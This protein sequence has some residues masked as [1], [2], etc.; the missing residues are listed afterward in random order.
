MNKRNKIYFSL[1]ALIALFGLLFG[2]NSCSKD[3]GKPKPPYTLP[4]T[5]FFSKHI[6]PLFNT[7]CNV[8]GCHSGSFPSGKLDL[9][10]GTAYN[11]LFKKDE[12]DTLNPE[13]S[14]LY[15]QMNQNGSPMPPDG[16]LD[17]YYIALVLK[18]IQHKAKNN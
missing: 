6:Q 3:I 11:D 18:W 17:D 12:V 16:K 1:F 7:Y 9:S 8:Q 2:L 14:I 13:Q 10:E 15:I 4:D 5:V